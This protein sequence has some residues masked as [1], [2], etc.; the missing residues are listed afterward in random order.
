MILLL[1]RVLLSISCVH[2]GL[3]QS[4]LDISSGRETLTRSYTG[5]EPL[6]VDLVTELRAQLRGMG[7]S[8]KDIAEGA[9]SER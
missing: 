3:W 9:G 2:C 5:V 8:G 7:Q 1:W 4:K 6:S